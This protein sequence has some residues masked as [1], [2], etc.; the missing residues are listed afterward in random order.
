[1][2]LF[3]QHLFLSNM[4]RARLISC[5]RKTHHSPWSDAETIPRAQCPTHLTLKMLVPHWEYSNGTSG[6][7]TLRLVG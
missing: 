6:R 7:D 5:P 1:M 2:R 3:D 4:L